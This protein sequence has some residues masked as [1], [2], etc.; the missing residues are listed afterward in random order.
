MSDGKRLRINLNTRAITRTASLISNTVVL[1]A[2]AFL[3]GS[4]IS[5]RFKDRKRER[6]LET[7]EMGAQIA[8][9]AAGL[10]KVIVET[11][12]RGQKHQVL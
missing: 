7:L 1:T 8:N 4:G 12:D 6:V 9:V 2:N 11:L 3:I 10:T 5:N